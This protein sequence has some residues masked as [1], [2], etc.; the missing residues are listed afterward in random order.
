MEKKEISE[1]R[2]L[3]KPESCVLTRIAGCYVSNE[4]E[5]VSKFKDA[6]LSVPEEEMFKY[7]DLFRKAFSG[8]IGK[9]LHNMEFPVKEQ[10]QRHK[11]LM[12]LKAE[13][14]EN[15][16][17]LD[18]FYNSVIENYDTTDN[19][20]ILLVHGTYDIPGKSAA[21]E[22]EKWS[23]EVYEHILCLFCP[24]TLDKASLALKDDKS[25]LRCKNRDWVIEAP[26]H[27]FLFPT[28]D[29]RQENV[30]GMLFYTKKSDDL[31]ETFLNEMFGVSYLRPESEQ[32]KVIAETLEAA[33][34]N[35][36]Q[37]TELKDKTYEMQEANDVIDS[38]E[39]EKL[40]SMCGIDA[41]GM[42]NMMDSQGCKK[43]MLSNTIDSEKTTI[44]TGNVTL[45]LKN[46]DLHNLELRKVDGRNCI[47]IHISNQVV[48]DG[49]PIKVGE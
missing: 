22:D 36:E 31:Q 49:I 39:M 4:K 26:K 27:A 29:D 46:D 2:K 42:S 23:E 8:K 19:Y 20:M 32:K 48:M 28:F 18:L 7:F 13:H 35:F 34:I 24:V 30:S 47:V 1:I 21:G 9:T 11:L 3:L 10:D 17:T 41:S 45:K 40:C 38:K 43:V 16:N 15:N 14:L 37:L 12:A 33:S 44:D 5:K 6:F 25:N